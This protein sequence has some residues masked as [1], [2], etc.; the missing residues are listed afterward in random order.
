MGGLFGSD[1]AGR[2]LVNNNNNIDNN[3][4][5]I[6]NNNNNINNNNYNN[7]LI[8]IEHYHDAIM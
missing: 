5:N 1:E 2:G 7:F 8:S 3:N 4:N 6:D